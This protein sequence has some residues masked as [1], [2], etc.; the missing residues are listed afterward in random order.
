MT[1]QE[2]T[3]SDFVERG[4]ANELINHR[5]KVG[6]VNDFIKKVREEVIKECKGTK[7]NCYNLNLK[8]SGLA[9]PKF[10]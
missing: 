10:K 3:L 7:A 5:I 2:P 6:K 1:E 9:G 4:T 8:I